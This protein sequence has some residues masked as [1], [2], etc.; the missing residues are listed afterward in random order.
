MQRVKV[1]QRVRIFIIVGLILVLL[2]G[3]WN[4]A[5]LITTNNRYDGFLKAVPKSEFGIHVIKKDGY[6]YGVSRPGYLSF[7]GNLAIN[8]S[9]EGNS[10]IIWPLIKGG[11]EYGIRIQQEGK[12]Y[13]IFLNEH[14]KPADNDDTKNQIF[15]QLKPEIDM[16]FEKAN[17]MWNLE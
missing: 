9:D 6:V 15:Q 14:L 2:F 7:T 12:V 10:L 4:V 16:L 17:L 3:A 13:E 1:K 8:N 11:Y 5:W